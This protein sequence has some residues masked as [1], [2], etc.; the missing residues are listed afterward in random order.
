M[1]S[2]HSCRQ[3]V[4]HNPDGELRTRAE[5]AHHDTKGDAVNKQSWTAAALAAAL[6]LILAGCSQEAPPAPA[7]APPPAEEA[8]AGA[9]DASAADAAGTTD[10]GVPRYEVD[11]SWP[12]ELP[13]NWILGQVAGIAVDSNDHV[14]LVHRPR[15]ITAHE[16]AAV[17]N[18]PTA[19][20]CT[21]APSVV[22]FDA[23][24]QF[25]QAW[26]GPTWDQA[27]GEWIDS[28]DDWP[29]N[30]HGI[31]V[32]AEDN[33]WLAGN[34]DADHIVLKMSRDGTRQLTI[35]RVGENGGSNDTERLGRPA[36][37]FVDTQARE[38]FVADGYLNRR[39]VVFNMDTG[40][41]KRHWGA[42]GNEPSDDPL[43]AYEPGGE[44][45]ADFSGPV[46]GIE[47]TSDGLVYVADRTSNRIQVF[48]Q[49]GTFVS[50]HIIAPWTLDQGAAWDI[51][52]AAFADEAWLFVSD[53]H[54]KRVW[55]LDRESMEVVDSFGR[56]GRQAGQFE[57]VH[58]I[59]ADSSGNLYTS[60]VNTGK[61]VQRFRRVVA[62]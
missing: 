18:P 31:F 32:D 46:H 9:A 59:A 10:T 11:A 58:N 1:Q 62:E 41:Y 61:R 15:T 26:G 45:F 36:D 7:E 40:A 50:E 22:E 20:C 54:N 52:R 4:L 17:Q 43:P 35:G 29:F 55:I 42:Y 12:G 21:P 47:L 25:V 3:G 53:G 56:G 23:D 24:G 16:A 38:V 34:G 30:E 44:P 6:L 19:D 5:P 57:W 14:W 39:V 48:E 49:D 60:E 2:N 27:S 37:V 51:E 28:E 13:E 33:V 8:D